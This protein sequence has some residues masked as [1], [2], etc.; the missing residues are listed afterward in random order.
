MKRAAILN[1]HWGRNN[2]GAVLNALA[3][4]ESLIRLGYET[5]LMNL[6]PSSFVK[7]R[8]WKV[9]LIRYVFL[10]AKVVMRKKI[11]VSNATDKIFEQFCATYLKRSP[12]NYYSMDELRNASLQFDSY[13]VGSDQVWRPRFAGEF[14]LGYFLEFVNDDSRRIAYAASF[15]GG[16][17]ECDSSE[18]TDSVRKCLHRFDSIS[19][20][21]DSGVRICRDVFDVGAVHVLDPTLIIGRDFFERI[22]EE[23]KND[24]S[25]KRLNVS[26]RKIAYFQLEESERFEAFMDDCGKRKGV[27]TINLR[28]SERKCLGKTFYYAR[29]IPEWLKV[30]RDSD[31]VVT[32]S[33]H[34]VCF[35]LIFN[36]DFICFPNSRG[37]ERLASL[38]R[39]VGLGKDRM[40]DKWDKH[41]W[42]RWICGESIDYEEVNRRL[43]NLKIISRQFLSKALAARS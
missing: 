4:Q 20:R 36:K 21:E 26:D 32:D 3:L 11:I 30:I 1:F 31:F 29:A 23:T 16:S 34:C 25:E 43:D 12:I 17:W 13:I 10:L 38:F 40:I 27:T 33:F 6:I 41:H 24:I 18:L 8:S 28:Y 9:K 14:A 19:V 7:D 5:E 37:V 15:G 35:A 22:I 2:Y 42:N 39:A